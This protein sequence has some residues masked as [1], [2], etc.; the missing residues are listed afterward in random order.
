MRLKEHLMR[1]EQHSVTPVGAQPTRQSRDNART[2]AGGQAGGREISA[3]EEP[4]TCY[5][6][7]TRSRSHALARSCLARLKIV[8]RHIRGH[9][10]ECILL[11]RKQI[12]QN[13]LSAAHT[14]Q[15][16]RNTS[17]QH[18]TPGRHD[19]CPHVN[20]D[21]Q[22]DRHITGGEAKSVIPA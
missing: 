5:G 22:T 12:P 1:D 9:G 14:Q 20:R 13:P 16:Q 11:A 10:T 15:L 19:A 6:R 7:S 4:A 21:R 8:T 3:R 2:R 17:P 18:P